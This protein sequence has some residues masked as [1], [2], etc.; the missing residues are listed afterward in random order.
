MSEPVELTEEQLAA[1]RY[2][3]NRAT[4]RGLA[5]VL[6][7]EAFVVLLVPRALAQTST[8]LGGLKTGLLL[9]FA[10]VLVAGATVLRRR[11]GIGFGSLV[12]VPFLLIGIWVPAFFV[13][14]VLFLGVWLYLLNLRHELIGT[15]GGVRML[16]S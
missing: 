2:N 7:L 4:R 16:V 11:W 6:C 12:Q 3:T 8:G 9:G 13:V 14:G 5:A 15:P 10:A 1:R